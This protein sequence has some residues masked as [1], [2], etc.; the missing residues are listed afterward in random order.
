ML[1]GGTLRAIGILLVNGQM[2]RVVKALSKRPSPPSQSPKDLIRKRQLT[3]HPV[4]F[5]GKFLQQGQK[6]AHSGSDPKMRR[7]RAANLSLQHRENRR[8][9][10][11]R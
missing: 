4:P 8:G 11:V 1:H 5:T 7:A 9:S 6:R 2:R 3:A 10:A